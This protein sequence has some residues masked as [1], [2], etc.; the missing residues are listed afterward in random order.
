MKKKEQI[1]KVKVVAGRLIR[2]KNTKKP[3][4]TNAKDMYYSVW[5]EDADGKNERALLFTEKELQRA[6][7]RAKR[8]PEDLPRKG[9][10]TNILD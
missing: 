1:D 6:E 9:F 3:S 7:H 4:L 2:V 5:V 8:N 10:F